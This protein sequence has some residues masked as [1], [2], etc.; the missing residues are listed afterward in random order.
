MNATF[1]SLKER[2]RSIAVTPRPTVASLATLTSF[3]SFASPRRI[4]PT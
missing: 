2:A 1:W 3:F 4:T